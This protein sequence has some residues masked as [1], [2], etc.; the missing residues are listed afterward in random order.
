MRFTFPK[1]AN[2]VVKRPAE[3]LTNLEERWVVP[4]RP[5]APVELQRLSS[6]AKAQV[7]PCRPHNLYLHL[8]STVPRAHLGQASTPDATDSA[9]LN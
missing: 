6:Q 5:N 9:R 2:N 7:L 4:S 3:M 1:F 8:L